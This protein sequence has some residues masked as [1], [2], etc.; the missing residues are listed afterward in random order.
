[1]LAQVLVYHSLFPTAPSQPR[2]AVS[3]DLVRF[4]WALFEHSCDAIHALASALKTHYAR[5]GFQMTHGDVS[6]FL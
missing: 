1:M 5:R 6:D 4:Y 2:M 3:I